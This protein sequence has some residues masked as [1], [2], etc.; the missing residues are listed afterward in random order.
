MG[1]TE[2]FK[3]N[4][5]HV[6]TAFMGCFFSILL[7]ASCRQDKEIKWPEVNTLDNLSIA[8]EA[9]AE[10]GNEAELDHTFAKIFPT[11]ENIKSAQPDE[12]KNKALVTLYLEELEAWS[13]DNGRTLDYRS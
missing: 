7:L 2:D 6:I 9:Y 5:A 12:L 10:I 4:R 13:I 8:A 1:K 3:M 11:I